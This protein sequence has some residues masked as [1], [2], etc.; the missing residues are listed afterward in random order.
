MKKINIF[1]YRL[2]IVEVCG[3][4]IFLDNNAIRIK[5]R[6]DNFLLY[7]ITDLLMR[8]NHLQVNNRIS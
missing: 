5:M 7:R 6:I 1:L 4:E 8:P 2:T 3:N